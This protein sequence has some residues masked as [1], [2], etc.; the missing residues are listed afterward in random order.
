MA[1]AKRLAA[2]RYLRHL[3]AMNEAANT[4]GMPPSRRFCVAPMME[5]VC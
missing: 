1:R 3:K 4:A 2:G 5:R